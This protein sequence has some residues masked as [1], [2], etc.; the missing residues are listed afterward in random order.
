MW[1]RSILLSEIIN[2]GRWKAELFAD[3]DISSLKTSNLPFFALGDLFSESRITL[4]PQEKPEEIFTYIGMENVESNT[5]DLIGDFLKKGIQIKSRS[6]IFSCG[7]ILYGRLRPNLNKVILCPLNIH[8]GICSGEFFVLNTIEEIVRP[9]VLREILASEFVLTQVTRFV[10]GA[11]L[12][13]VSISDLATIEVPLPDIEI[14]NELEQ[15]LLYLDNRRR[16]L[17]KEL[18]EFPLLFELALKKSQQLV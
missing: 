13:R 11:A 2:A 8:S 5:G 4:N 18:S 12:P 10:A 6:K 1:T 17:K 15:N 14:Q 16:Y 7:Q 9:R 3:R